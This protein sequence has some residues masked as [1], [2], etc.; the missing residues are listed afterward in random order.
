MLDP[1]PKETVTC[2]RGKEFTNHQELTDQ[3]KVQVY[4]P[5]SHTPWQRGTNENTNELLREYFPKAS[6]LTF[7]DEHT[8]QLWE[9]KLNNGAQKC[10]NWKTPYEVFYGKIVHLI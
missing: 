6:D 7:A 4:F 3:L 10:P 1:L 9:D 2:D 8:I 5:D